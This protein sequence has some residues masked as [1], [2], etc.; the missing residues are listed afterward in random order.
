MKTLAHILLKN[1]TEMGLEGAAAY[2]GSKGV[3]VYGFTGEMP[4]EEVRAAAD[5][6]LARS[7]EFAEFRGKNFFQHKND[8]PIHGFQNFD[9]EVFPKQESLDG[10]NFGNLVR[11]PM[12]KNWKNPKDPTFFL[13]M[14]TP[15]GVFSAH[16]DPVKLLE[17]GNPFL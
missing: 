5:I 12:G 11:L 10:K 3:H 6:C 17:T 4:A 14:T 8:D 7:G 9:V 15:L 1:V 16:S 2:S 13:D